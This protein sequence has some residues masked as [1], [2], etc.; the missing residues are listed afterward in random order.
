M[1][2][3]QKERFVTRILDSMFNTVSYKRIAILVMHLKKIQTM[4][5]NFR[6]CHLQETTGRKGTTCHL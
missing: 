5:E 1:N 4:P 3:Y 2:E 6:D